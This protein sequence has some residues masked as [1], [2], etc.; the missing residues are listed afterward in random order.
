MSAIY[1]LI[2]A[3]RAEAKALRALATQTANSAH[4]YS[5]MLGFMALAKE[6][7]SDTLEAEERKR[8]EKLHGER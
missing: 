8:E 5:R 1:P 7:A 4:D 6:T 3:L 2:R